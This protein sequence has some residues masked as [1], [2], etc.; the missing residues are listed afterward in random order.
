ML[1]M[2]IGENIKRIRETKGWTQERLANEIDVTQGLI[3][4]YE[5]NETRQQ[6]DIIDRIAKALNTNTGLLY[7]DPSII[8]RVL[9]ENDRRILGWFDGY[10]EIT[11]LTES[12]KQDII[13]I[14]K[15]ADKILDKRK[16]NHDQNTKTP[17]PR[18]AGA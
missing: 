7:D 2:G 18:K 14:L 3:S 8:D 9:S 5:R 13:D 1:N 17:A 15:I 16:V 11:D 6:P 10:K 12:E 4:Q